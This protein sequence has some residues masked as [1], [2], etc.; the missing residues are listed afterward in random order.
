[1]FIKK[2]SV[3]LSLVCL[4][5]KK[6]TKY[7]IKTSQNLEKKWIETQAKIKI[8]VVNLIVIHTNMKVNLFVGHASMP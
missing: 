3:K 2:N 7:H 5:V 8:Y 4:F 6:G 1:M